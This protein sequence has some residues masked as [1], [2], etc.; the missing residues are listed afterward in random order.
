MQREMYLSVMMDRG[1]QVS[2]F[3]YY[4]QAASAVHMVL[5]IHV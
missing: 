5:L 1:A 2:G 4:M 3:H